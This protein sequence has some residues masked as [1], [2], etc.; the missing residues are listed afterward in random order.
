MRHL[1]S[2]SAKRSC[3]FRKKRAISDRAAAVVTELID[4]SIGY[5][6]VG[7]WC[8]WSGR[9]GLASELVGALR[10]RG[11][12]VQ[13]GMPMLVGERAKGDGTRTLLGK[14]TPC[15]GRDVELSTLTAM[16]TSGGFS[17]S[18]GGAARLHAGTTAASEASGSAVRKWIVR[19]T[20]G[21]AIISSTFEKTG[22]IQASVIAAATMA[23]IG[24]HSDRKSVV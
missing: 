17:G 23:S 15:V 20:V 16:A 9:D 2:L 6:M 18:G 24:W 11:V 10:A 4:W 13:D 22:G 21:T 8:E 14:A 1:R 12:R 3:V 19:S 5:R 7:A